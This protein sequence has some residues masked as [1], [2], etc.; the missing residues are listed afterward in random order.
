MADPNQKYRI[1][2]KLDE[3]GMAE[4]YRA[5]VE[6]IQGFKKQVAIK[7][8]LPHLTKNQKFVSMF[9]D[10]ARLSLYLNHANIVQVFDI[11]RSENTFFIVMEYVHGL[12]LRTLVESLRRQKRRVEIQHA[13][14][15]IM[16]VAKGLGYAHDMRDPETDRHLDIVHRDISPPN[17]LLSRMGE[18]KLVDFGL[19]KAA[20]QVERTDPGV[21]KGKFSYLSPEA[22]AGNPVDHRA[23]IFA[24]GIIFFEML[25]GRRLFYGET[26]LQTVELVRQARVPPMSALNPDISPELERIVRKALALE[27]EARYQHAYEIHETLAQFLFSRGMKVTN[28]DIGRLVRNCLTEHRMTVPPAVRSD[29]VIDALI[30]EEVLKFTSL[31]T[32]DPEEQVGARPLSPAELGPPPGGGGEMVDT[33]SWID[34]LNDGDDGAVLTFPSQ[35]GELVVEKV[36]TLENLVLEDDGEPVTGGEAEGKA[37]A[38][39]DAEVAGGT[40]TAAPERAAAA[41]NLGVWRGVIIALV[42]LLVLGGASLVV[43]WTLGALR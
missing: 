19:A 33:R 26:D 2:E 25:T 5:E 36:P 17:I 9:L 32:F 24:C 37:A 13:I 8:V 12:N 6:S 29:N 11:G 27:P 7:R 23:D 15:I 10:E 21:V 20:S 31:D 40:A 43:L 4:I 18:V 1:I 38:Q 39:A 16:E 14:F 28:Q 35:S 34:E 22:A 30:Q 42:V 3:G 41:A